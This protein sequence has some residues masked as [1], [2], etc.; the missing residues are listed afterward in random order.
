VFVK[1][2]GAPG[3]RAPIVEL[4]LNA[5][6]AKPQ[7]MQVDHREESH[8]WLQVGVV[9]STVAGKAALTLRNIG[10]GMAALNAVA[11]SKRSAP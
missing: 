9:E 4:E 7:V 11:W 1:W 5:P 8:K 2:Y 10:G 6:G 3:D